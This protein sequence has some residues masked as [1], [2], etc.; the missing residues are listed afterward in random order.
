MIEESVDKLREDLSRHA[1]SEF[2]LLI[3]SEL[4]RYLELKIEAD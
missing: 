2:N 1:A 3:T 4:R